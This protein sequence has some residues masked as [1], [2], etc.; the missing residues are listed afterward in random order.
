MQKIFMLLLCSTLAGC[1]Y[2]QAFQEK[3]NTDTLVYQCENNDQPLVVKRNNQTQQVH[4]TYQDTPLILAEGLSAMGQRYS[5]G[6]YVLWM[7]DKQDSVLYRK[8]NIVLNHCQ[9]TVK[10]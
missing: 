4:L 5:D 2:Y 1:S 8:D 9:L 7:K 6:V 10:H 3:M